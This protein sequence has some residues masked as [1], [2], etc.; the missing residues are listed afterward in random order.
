MSGPRIVIADDQQ[1]VLAALRLLLKPEGYAT[2]TATS[3]AGLLA[4][5]PRRLMPALS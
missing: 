2:Q 3:P 1:D 5:L 4:D